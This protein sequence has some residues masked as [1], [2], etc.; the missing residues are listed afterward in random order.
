VHV[1]VDLITDPAGISLAEPDDCARFAV[2]VHGTGGDEDLHR[3]LVGASVGR[4]EGSEALVTVA[5]VRTLASRRVG[6]AWEADFGAM[7][8]YARA[9][10]W[11]TDEADAI[12]AH[13]EW[14]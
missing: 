12:R 6:S 11:L 10:G 3:A 8:E 2:V 7:L 14:R 5:A 9:R 4:M 13:V 1:T